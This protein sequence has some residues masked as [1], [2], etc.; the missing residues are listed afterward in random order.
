MYMYQ[1]PVR[2]FGRVTNLCTYM[3]KLYRSFRHLLQ[4]QLIPDKDLVP[5]TPVLGLVDASRFVHPNLVGRNIVDV[6]LDPLVPSMGGVDKVERAVPVGGVIPDGDPG[7][8]TATK[9]RGVGLP[10]AVAQDDVHRPLPV[11][12]AVVHRMAA[13]VGVQVAGQDEVD[14]VLVEERFEVPLGQEALRIV[15]VPLEGVVHGTVEGAGDPRGD[16]PVDRR[17]LSDEPLV[18]G[19][20]GTEVPERVEDDVVGQ[21]EPEAVEGIAKVVREGVGDGLHVDRVV[22]VPP[23][24]GSHLGHPEPGLV[25]GKDLPVVVALHLVVARG[26]HEGPVVE[27]RRVQVQDVEEV[28]PQA[29]DAVGVGNVAHAQD[30]GNF[31]NFVVEVGQRVEGRLGEGHVANDGQFR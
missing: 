8:R 16:V 18:L 31:L 5:D 26:H 12:R 10:P 30:G 4:I 27:G 6:R 19:T 25:R 21:P 23:D 13:L 11:Q 9:V 2:S 17:Q 1:I 20:P 28:V 14:P 22:V 24:H 15:P 3:Y 7:L 29:V